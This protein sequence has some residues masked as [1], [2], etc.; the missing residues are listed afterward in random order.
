MP[1]FNEQPECETSARGKMFA[2]HKSDL[3]A[4]MQDFTLAKLA[5]LS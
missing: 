2:T 5:I 1:F 4:V 3:A